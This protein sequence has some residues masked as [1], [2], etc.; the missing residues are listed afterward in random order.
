[1]N[2]RLLLLLLL[3]PTLLFAQ[4]YEQMRVGQITIIPENLPS[5][6]TFD[7]KALRTRLNTKE[8]S[9]FS[10]FEFDN[11]LKMLAEEYESADPSFEICGSQLN[12]TLRIYLKP[13]IRDI[14]FC[15]NERVSSKRLRKELDL[16]RGS[17]YDREEFI[18]AF[19]KVRRL[20][21]KKGYFESELDFEV[22]PIEACN[23]V[24]I[25]IKVD[26]GR[27]G[28]IGQ[29]NF[30][31]ATSCEE[32]E[33]LDMMV[34]KKYNFL[35]SWYIG[36]GAYNPEMIDH[37][38]LQIVNYYQN[39][40]YA[41]AT[42]DIC[43]RESKKDC[44]IS[45]EIT[46]DRGECYHIGNMNMT[47]NCIFTNLQIWD[48]FTLG[49][50]SLYSPEKLRDSIKNITDLYGGCGYIDANVDIQLSLRDDAPI[51][52]LCLIINEGEQ[53][54]VGMVKVFGNHCTNT[55]LILH[56]SILCPGEVFNMRKLKGTE[57]RLQNT[58][59]F[60]NVNVYAVRSQFEDPCSDKLYR[61]VYIEV[62]ETDT[63]NVGLF[64]GFSSIERIFGGVEV[65]EANFNL[66]GLTRVLEKGPAALRGAGEYAHFKVNIGDRQTSY[67][68]QWTKPY[69]LDTPWIVG[70]DLEKNDNRALS[71]AY[72]LKTWGG[73]VH[74]TYIC[75]EFLKYNI[76]YRAIR[77]KTSTSRDPNVQLQNAADKSGF[78]SASGVN[79]IYDSTDHP[80]RPTNG[81]RS[82]LLYEIAGLGGNYQFMKLGYLNTYYYP[83]TKKGVLKFRGELQFIHT[84]G[85]TN[86]GSLPLSER[87]YLG[88]ETTVRGYKPFSIGPLFGNL[89]PRGGV[90]SMLLS[91]E[92]QHNLLK[93]PCVDAFCFVDA[94][95]VSLS[96]F[97]IAKYGASVGLG[98]RFE[99]MRNVPMMLGYAWPIHPIVYVKGRP[100]DNSQRFFFSMGGNF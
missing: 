79:F 27:A 57:S 85:D 10:Q 64:F 24:D 59:Y 50:G 47:G 95:M 58:G 73:S 63:G 86:E 97:T 61:D 88:G 98:L 93:V 15:S 54:H 9:Y 91:E 56:E 94:G 2:I 53:Y 33:I 40:G 71:R 60:E 66:A 92:Y 36:T 19:N 74:A 75:N 12:I 35:L 29:I 11:D 34:T 39:N 90:S 23:E 26:E 17:Y 68:A 81:F 48:K 52:D 38:R 84:Y 37:D 7:F 4:N 62:Q 70:I 25:Y 32:D 77:T 8:G 41:D 44:R 6:T 20:Y 69:F 67:L 99:A 45:V 18:T 14:I 3:L 28:K 65:S 89:E 30:H 55:N 21:V 1:M 76:Y 49:V 100:I 42:A 72:E 80:R 51:Y 5:S 83:L 43:L 87:L 78:I 82:R 46:I 13:T 16:E 31:G 22:L 96:E